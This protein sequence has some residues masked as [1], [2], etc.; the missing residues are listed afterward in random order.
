MNAAHNKKY[1]LFTILVISVLIVS[2][3]Y[4]IYDSNKKVLALCDKKIILIPAGP[5]TT[6]SYYQY[7][8]YEGIG[9]GKDFKSKTEAI[10]YCKAESI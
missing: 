7:R 9:R 4:Y 2:I 10:A 3:S 8:P 1:V 6:E 5:T